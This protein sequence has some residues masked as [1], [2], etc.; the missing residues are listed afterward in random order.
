MRVVG[1]AHDTQL[2]QHLPAE[3][4]ALFDL[5]RQVIERVLALK[6]GNVSQTALF[7]KVPR[8]VLAYR[9]EKYGISKKGR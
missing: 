4:I 7:L 5:E 6:E 3:G 8:H 1:P 2:A 9:M